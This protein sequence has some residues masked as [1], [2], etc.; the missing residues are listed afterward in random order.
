VKTITESDLARLQPRQ[1]EWM[2]WLARDHNKYGAAYFMGLSNNSTPR[3]QNA[4]RFRLGLSRYANLKA[5]AR[6]HKKW[7]LKNAI[8]KGQ[9]KVKGWA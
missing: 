9:G 7:I 1:L 4:I 2:Y 8:V 6:T 3:R 5:I